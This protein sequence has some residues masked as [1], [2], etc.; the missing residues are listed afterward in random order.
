MRTRTALLIGAGTAVVLGCII[1]VIIVAVLSLSELPGSAPGGGTLEELPPG[2]LTPAQIFDRVAR[3]YE[4]CKS[5]RDSGAVKTVYTSAEGPGHTQEQSFKTAF[6]RPDRFRFE[7]TEESPR[8]QK[9]YI[10]WTDGDEAATWWD[11]RP[12]IEREESLGMALAGATGVSSGSAHTIPRLLLPDE[13]GGRALAE[14]RQAERIE[15]GQM[16][17]RTCFRIRGS[18]LSQSETIWIDR[19]TFLVLRIDEQV[20]LRGSRAET[21]TT[22]EPAMN[23]EISPEMLEF[24]APDTGAA[25]TRR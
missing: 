8:G 17:G 7:F 3:I 1:T 6:V 18:V 13:V 10:V 4:S 15:N 22:Y 2:E 21:T 19:E 25:S 5:Y 12:G 14:L 11:I 16:Y 24:N 23:V 20:D 9:R